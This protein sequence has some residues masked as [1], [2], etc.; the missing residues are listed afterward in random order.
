VKPFSVTQVNLVE[1][2]A[3][4][5]VIAIQNARLFNDTREALEQ[6]TDTS[7]VL[8]V[9]SSSPGGLQPVFVKMLENATRV[10]EANFGVMNLY[11]GEKFNIVADHNVPSAFTAYRQRTPIHPLPDTAHGEIVRT[12]Q[13]VQVSDPRETPGY[14]S[15]NPVMVRMADV[16]G[17]RTLMTVPMLKEGELLGTIAIYRTEVRPFTDK[18]VS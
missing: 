4:Q 9:I 8:E 6:Q 1:T 7:E 10:C 12:H 2:F 17:A 3:D 13:V 16:A 5:A 18:Q 14:Q 11:D 15:G